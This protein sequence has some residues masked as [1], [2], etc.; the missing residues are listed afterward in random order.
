[1]FSGRAV[2]ILGQLQLL[3]VNE[4]TGEQVEFPLAIG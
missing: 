2:D 4:A 1:M 3:I